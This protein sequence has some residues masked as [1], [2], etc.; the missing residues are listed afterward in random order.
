MPVALGA[1]SL[2]LCLIGIRQLAL[3]TSLTLSGPVWVGE[4]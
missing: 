4:Y 1:L 3:A 2:E